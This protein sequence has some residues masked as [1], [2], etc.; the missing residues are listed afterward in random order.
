[1]ITGNIPFQFDMSE[2]IQR[3]G[4]FL[5]NR[6]GDV[7]VS[8]PFVSFGVS[9]KDKERQ[10]ARELVI[11]LRDRRVLSAWDVLRRLHRQRPCLASG[12]TADPRDKRVVVVRV[13]VKKT[14]KTPR[15]EIDLA[16]QRAKEVLE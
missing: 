14:Q 7:T 16:L 15:R 1:M 4:T 13:F 9:P 2:L 5:N 8:L 10:I 12:D 3:G 6:V 11:R